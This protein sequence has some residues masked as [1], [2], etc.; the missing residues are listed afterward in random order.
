[1]TDDDNIEIEQAQQKIVDQGE[2]AIARAAADLGF[3]A[4][5]LTA[6]IKNAT[7]RASADCLGISDLANVEALPEHRKSHATKCTFCTSVIKAMNEPAVPARRDEFIAEV[8]E[9]QT[10]VLAD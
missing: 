8:H 3:S 10:P 1:M 4:S 6:I 2:A 5:E 7:V 9:A